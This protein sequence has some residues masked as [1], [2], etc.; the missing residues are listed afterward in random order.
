MKVFN[1]KYIKTF[2]L[3]K[4]EW[5]NSFKTVQ[6]YNH[7]KVNGKVVYYQENNGIQRKDALTVKYLKKLNFGNRFNTNHNNGMNF[8]NWMT[9]E[10]NKKKLKSANISILKTN[11]TYLGTL[12]IENMTLN[13]QNIK[14]AQEIDEN[15]GLKFKKIIIKGSKK[16][17]KEFFK[18]SYNTDYVIPELFF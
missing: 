7:K 18:N 2:A 1:G 3:N 11:S 4:L 9:K 6:N 12:S 16:K 5:N 14:I 8:N 13:D 17:S 10:N 15:Y